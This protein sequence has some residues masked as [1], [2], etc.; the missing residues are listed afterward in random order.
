ME[1]NALVY[2]G[3]PVSRISGEGRAEVL[4][5]WGPGLEQEGARGGGTQ[6]VRGNYESFK[7]TS[8]TVVEG[9]HQFIMY[10]L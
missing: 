1:G 10:T 9:M 8:L 4:R 2:Q 6:S 3:N 5:T 7:G